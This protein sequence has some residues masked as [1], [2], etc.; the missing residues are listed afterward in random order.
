M[1]P[2]AAPTLAFLLAFACATSAA[3]FGD[4]APWA[5][6]DSHGDDLEVSLVTFGVG[7][8]IPSWW[9]HVALLVEDERYGVAR[10]YNFG[11]FTFDREM[12][13]KFIRGRLEFWVGEDSWRGTVVTYRWFGRD[14]F[15]QRL[16]LPPERKL[17]L[18]QRLAWYVLPENRDYLYDHYA[19]NCSTR[20][21][22]LI[23]EAAFG[24]LRV[25]SQGP[26]RLTLRAHTL[27]HTERN[28]YIAWV[29]D[30]WLNASVDRPLLAWDEMFLPEELRR[31]VARLHYRD[32]AGVE[33]ML[34][35]PVEAV[36][37]APK[38]MTTPDRPWPLWPWTLASGTILGAVSVLLGRRFARRRTLRSRLLYGLH[39]AFIG[40]VVGVPG[41]LLF[42]M[43]V[44]TDHTVTWQNEN[45]WLGGPLPF[46]GLPI[47]VALML[48]WR[49]APAVSRA[50]WDVVALM[51]ITLALFKCG[52][53]G[54]QQ[55]LTLTLSAL[56]PLNVGLA[57]AGHV[58]G[59]PPS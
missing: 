48:N 28:P 24:Q 7:D 58:G 53:V 52:V 41:I 15:L 50:V 1:R 20:I 37:L 56:L 39:Q 47:A 6:G 11:M 34:A 25:A 36:F 43:A 40:L 27:R 22:D 3:A 5:R 30:Y 10:V 9:G 31:H 26:A 54:C 16:D 17:W 42:A 21:R 33:R 49:H 59:K 4:D 18:A 45:L 38:R 13:P 14:I 12:I 32:D 23:D 57:L 44:F 2:R 8:D 35:G 19:D 55:D 46:L 29:L 51:T